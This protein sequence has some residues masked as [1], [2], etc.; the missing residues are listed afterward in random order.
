MILTS[1]QS[2]AVSAF[3]CWTCQNGQNAFWMTCLSAYIIFVTSSLLSPYRELGSLGFMLPLLCDLLHI[4]M[5]CTVS[6]SNPMFFP[7]C[8]VSIPVIAQGFA[9]LTLLLFSF[10]TSPYRTLTF[11][12]VLFLAP[13]SPDQP[14]SGHVPLWLIWILTTF[15][16]TSC[17]LLSRNCFQVSEP[18]DHSGSPTFTG[19]TSITIIQT[20]KHFALK[21]DTFEQFNHT[22]KVSLQ[23]FIKQFTM[24]SFHNITNDDLH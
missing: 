3:S 6:G 20:I 11:H 4:H 17:L 16:N 1:I 15:L 21:K 19:T 18:L 10:L 8:T 7:C 22:L 12:D 23:I 24:N 2:V 13:R 14:Q 5:I 9:E